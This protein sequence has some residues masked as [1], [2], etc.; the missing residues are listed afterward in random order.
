MK[1]KNIDIIYQQTMSESGFLT[2]LREDVVDKNGY[3]V[4]IQPIRKL[5]HELKSPRTSQYYR[6]KVE[7]H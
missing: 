4:L 6:Q 5:T 1:N 3:L 2:K 7:C